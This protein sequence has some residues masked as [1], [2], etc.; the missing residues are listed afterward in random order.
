MI[1]HIAIHDVGNGH[2]GISR[3]QDAVLLESALHEVAIRRGRVIRGIE[4]EHSQPPSEA[5]EHGVDEKAPVVRS[6]CG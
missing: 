5:A 4:A 3:E 2:E 6:A 1:V